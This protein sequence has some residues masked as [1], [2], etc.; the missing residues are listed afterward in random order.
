MVALAA[1]AVRSTRH[2]WQ[3]IDLESVHSRRCACFATT[4]FNVYVLYA[5]CSCS[6]Q[7]FL[8][9]SLAVYFSDLEDISCLSFAK[10][11]TA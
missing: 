11:M 9:H 2:D 10:L 6:L 8:S 5:R 3:Q 7:K 1:Q 4:E